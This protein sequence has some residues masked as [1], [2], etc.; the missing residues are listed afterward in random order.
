MAHSAALRNLIHHGDKGR[1]NAARRHFK[2]PPP[3]APPLIH[4]FYRLLLPHVGYHIHITR[5]AGGCDNNIRDWISLR[6]D[7]SLHLFLAYLNALGYTLTLTKL[8]EKD[9]S[10]EAPQGV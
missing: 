2:P 1:T 9:T 7:P 10:H 8:K 3:N 6:R 5:R 4:H